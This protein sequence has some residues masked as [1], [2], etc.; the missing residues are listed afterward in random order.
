MDAGI[1]Y[2]TGTLDLLSG[3]LTLDT[4][5]LKNDTDP[6]VARARD[7]P[8][9]RA[10]LIWSRFPFWT[11]EETREGARVSV[12]DLRFAGRGGPFVQ[13]VVVR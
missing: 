1:G 7:A 9:I 6:R 12:S 8:H 2:E 10:F 5:I 11:I 13:S 4:V 3:Q